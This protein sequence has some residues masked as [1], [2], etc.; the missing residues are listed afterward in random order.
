MAERRRH[1]PA[2]QAVLDAL[3]RGVVLR[4]EHPGFSERGR[5]GRTGPT[6]KAADVLRAVRLGH[7]FVDVSH[8]TPLWEIEVRQRV[9]PSSSA[10]AER[11]D[12]YG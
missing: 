7:A 3:A 5:P 6:Y 1:D 4:F 10:Q 8:G 12:L 2:L 11:K 9:K